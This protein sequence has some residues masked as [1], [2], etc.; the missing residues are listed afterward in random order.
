[1]S[2]GVWANAQQADYWTTIGGP[3]WVLEQRQFDHML[4]AFGAE[5]QRVLAAQP[6]EHV[7]DV[8]CGTGTST[9]AIAHSVGA[10]GSVVGCDISPTMIDAARLRAATSPQVSLAIAD[11]QTDD[12]LQAHAFDAVY[13]R[14]GVMFFADPVAAF[15]NIAAAVRPEGR[16]VFVCWQHEDANEW[17]AV[18]ARIMRSF[19]P[20]PVLPPPD[21]PGPFAFRDRSRIESILTAARWTNVSISPYSARLELGGGDGIEPAVQQSMGNRA[22]QG[23]RDQVNDDTYQRATDAVR[24]ALAEHL[25][26]DGAVEMKGAVW[27]VTAT[28]P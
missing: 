16:L 6:G 20:E 24:Q 9:L 2:D 8:G 23:L 25:N 11:A 27:V 10:T 22:G 4:A 18:P 14:F 15:T 1:M 7:L 28:R 5:S 19:T 12:L 26:D 21:A 17:M 13:S 3:H